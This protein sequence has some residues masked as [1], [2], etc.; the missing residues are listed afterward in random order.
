MAESMTGE[1]VFLS[2]DRYCPVCGSGSIDALMTDFD[3]D[4]VYIHNEC[5]ECGSKFTFGYWVKDAYIMKDG[6]DK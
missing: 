1:L 4:A 2:T 3:T 5:G 6:R